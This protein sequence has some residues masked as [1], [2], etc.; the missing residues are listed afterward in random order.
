MRIGILGTGTM[1]SAL[2]AGWVRAGHEVVVGGRS[3]DRARRLAHGLGGTARAASQRE[4]VTGQEVVL[5]AVPWAGA[6]DVVREVGGPTGTLAGTTVIDPTNPVDFTTGALLVEPGESGAGRLAALAPGARLVKAFHLFPASRWPVARDGGAA[7]AVAM[8]GDDP[9]A[10]ER[11]A[12]LVRDLGG[13]PAALGRLDRARQLEE[14]AGFATSLAL[15]GTDP[16]SALPSLP[17]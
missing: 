15:S 5:L 8:C 1:A 9:V 11:V 10:V 17:A 2:G 3:R 16:R 13:V 6:A 7:P 4:A 14:I 12:S